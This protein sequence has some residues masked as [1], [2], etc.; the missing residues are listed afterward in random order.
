MANKLYEETA[1]QDIADAIREKTSSTDT[2][3]VAEMGDAIR[4]IPSGGTSKPIKVKTIQLTTMEDETFDISQL[5]LSECTSLLNFV[6]YAYGLTS[7]NGQINVPLS[8]NNSYAFSLSSLSGEIKVNA[9]LTTNWSECFETTMLTKVDI[10]VGCTSSTTLDVQYLVHGSEYLEE[11]NVENDGVNQDTDTAI[12]INSIAWDCKRLR[13]LNLK[14][15]YGR[16]TGFS[17]AFRNCTSLELLDIRNITFSQN[18][19]GSSNAVQGLNRDVKIIVKDQAE[20]DWWA[21]KY[22]SYNFSTYTVEEAIEQGIVE[23]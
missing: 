1:I 6:H 17:S 4:S 18:T 16:V 19:T 8:T 13:I 23:E 15:L 14:G 10:V 20:K 3:K 12:Q 22:S 2:Y 7:I 11:L 5:D 9:P 21:T